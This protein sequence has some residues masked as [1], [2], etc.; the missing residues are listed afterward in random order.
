MRRRVEQNK[1]T[2]IKTPPK[3][4]RRVSQ[5]ITNERTRWFLTLS[6]TNWHNYIITIIQWGCVCCRPSWRKLG[7]SC[8]AVFIHSY[9]VKK[10]K[11]HL[12]LTISGTQWDCLH[13]SPW[14]D[15]KS[16]SHLFPHPHFSLL[17]RHS[18]FAR[19]LKQCQ[20][21]PTPTLIP[22]SP[23]RRQSPSVIVRFTSSSS[24]PRSPHLGLD[25]DFS[26]GNIYQEA[27]RLQ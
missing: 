2:K 27:V 23:P 1:Y 20:W 12:H 19:A 22:S 8:A 18:L 21:P 13:P 4:H 14:D 25:L 11:W 15:P 9:A 16:T 6:Q 17:H 10:K 3:D 26:P 24:S 5:F 7:K